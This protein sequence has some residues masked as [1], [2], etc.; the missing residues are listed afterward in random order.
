MRTHEPCVPTFCGAPLA[1]T[2][3]EE[4]VAV[5]EPRRGRWTVGRGASPVD[6]NASYKLA[7][8]GLAAQAVAIAM[9]CSTP[10]VVRTI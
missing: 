1:G 7:L 6:K 5:A 8:Q 10:H 2:L 3:A 4:C 9:P